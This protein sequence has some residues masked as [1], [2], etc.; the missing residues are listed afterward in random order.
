MAEGQTQAEGLR[1]TR[2]SSY[3]SLTGSLKKTPKGQSELATLNWKLVGTVAVARRLR[4]GSNNLP[5]LSAKDV[6][7][8]NGK[9]QGEDHCEIGGRGLV[10]LV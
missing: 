2:E 10:E 5:K 8:L 4:E 6:S 1:N 3:A 7:V 9:A